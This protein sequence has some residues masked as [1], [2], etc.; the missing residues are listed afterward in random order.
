MPRMIAPWSAQRIM[1]QAHGEQGDPTPRMSTVRP[2]ARWS[3]VSLS[4][5]EPEAVA[6]EMARVSRR[7]VIR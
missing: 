2:V 4:L 7:L 6:A 3:E 1:S 5:G